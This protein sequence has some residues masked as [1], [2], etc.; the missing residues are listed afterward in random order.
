MLNDYHKHLEKTIRWLIRSRCKRGG[1][2]GYYN[3]LLGWSKPYPETTGYIIP[4]LIDYANEYND[5]HSKEIALEFGQ[6][7][8]T[9]QNEDGSWNSG[10]HPSRRAIP[11]IFNTAQVLFGLNRLHL[12]TGDE[13]WKKSSISAAGWLANLVNEQG[14]WQTGHY[15]N[16]NPTYYSRVAW[17]ML[18]TSKSFNLSSV[19]EKSVLVL[20]TLI[21]RKRENG[22]FEGWGFEDRKPAFTH[23]VAYTLRGFLESSILLDDWEKY[24][25]Q[26]EQ[27][28]QK[29]YEF[30]ELNNGRL[31]GEYDTNWNFN[32][33]YTCLTGNLQIA[34]CLMRWYE[35]NGD[36]RLLNA[37]SK[38]IE[39]VNRTQSQ[40]PAFGPLNGSVTGSKPIWGKYMMGRYPNWAAKFYADALMLFLKLSKKKQEGW[41]T[42]VS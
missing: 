3:I 20:N 26:T 29:F 16:F 9:I 39:F 7:L 19:K 13:K 30:A 42:A 23:T 27:A 38:L 24:G 8:L 32:N 10:L 36:L 31:A 18:L 2:S 22:T 5:N 21:R 11:S 34:I 40:K 14:F 1:S 12:E 35:I 17:P 33:K 6:W 15:Q 41:S 37:A 4:T 25:K 28:L